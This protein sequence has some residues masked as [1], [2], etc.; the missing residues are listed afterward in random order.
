MRAHG[1]RAPSQ[2]DPGSYELAA[3]CTT[4]PPCPWLRARAPLYPS[5][6]AATLLCY[7][8]CATQAVVGRE[9]LQAALGRHLGV[10]TAAV[11]AGLIAHFEAAAVAAAS[12]A[13]RGCSRVIQHPVARAMWQEFVGAT[14]EAVG[15]PVLAACLRSFLSS[16]LRLPP[17][18]VA[19]TLPAD[20][21]QCLARVLDQ[22]GDGVVSVVELDAVMAP[23]D[24]PFPDLLAAL[25]AGGRGPLAALPPLPPGPTLGLDA[26][27][28][29][30]ARRL[31]VAASVG[32]G[33]A[34]THAHH[35][36]SHHAHAPHAAGT[37]VATLV[38]TGGPGAGVSHCAVVLAHAA[39]DTGAWTGGVVLAA[40]P[41]HPVHVM[42]PG[43]PA[44]HHPHQNMVAAALCA[45]LHMPCTGA[46]AALAG[47]E[48]AR[49]RP[50]APGTLVVVDAGAAPLGRVLREVQELMGGGMAAPTVVV[51]GRPPP[52]PAIP[53]GAA[54]SAPPAVGVVVAHLSPLSPEA[55]E[56]LAHH[57]APRLN[58]DVVAAVVAAARGNPA[59]VLALCKGGGLPVLPHVELATRGDSDSATVVP[60]LQDLEALIRSQVVAAAAAAVASQAGSLLL[61]VVAAGVPAG[62]PLDAGL[63]GRL[64]WAVHT[65]DVTGGAGGACVPTTMHAH[66]QQLVSCGVLMAP[67][68]SCAPAGPPRYALAAH[69]AR[70]V[71]ALVPPTLRLLCAAT[72]TTACCDV[73]DA[74]DD[75][76]G[77][78]ATLAAE[79]LLRQG[80]TAVD[81]ALALAS[82]G[83]LAGLPRPF[84]HRLC[85]VPGTE[86]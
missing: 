63:L 13:S 56:A 76:W 86:C 74:T 1:Q 80:R 43:V 52:G 5:C 54:L 53:V 39:A 85:T 60:A 33:D 44:P 84:L 73:L 29:A 75:L 12:T 37:P 15:V 58:A 81:T 16:T 64:A 26:A 8:W 22:D 3:A 62:E 82:A 35:T 77:A 38:V 36:H 27:L 31:E 55:S 23:Y 20:A 50:R 83:R 59:A 70:A 17:H 34:H 46:G 49:R 24:A 4:C 67:P 28:A 7:I 48:W 51:L 19:A 65:G 57:V 25:V 21:T 14:V 41:S 11:Q 40:L 30:V 45:A 42:G 18:L 61:A 32:V 78:G 47:Q 6:T 72:V 68:P 10:T 2:P 66:L 79:A 69:A 9:E 71:A